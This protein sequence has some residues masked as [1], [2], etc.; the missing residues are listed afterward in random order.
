ME[1]M[2]RRSAWIRIMAVMLALVT[3]ITMM[4]LDTFAAAGKDSG[5]A[6]LQ[7]SEEAAD[8]FVTDAACD[9]AHDDCNCADCA[10]DN[11]DCADQCGE[12]HSCCCEDC[13]G[14]YVTDG[15]TAY[16]DPDKSSC[17]D[18]GKHSYY[19]DPRT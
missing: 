12:S 15:L 16:G 14:H 9:H 2:K 1:K 11:C 3:G 19:L 8:E 7:G 6:Y 17:T 4:P 13:N 5:R 10:L 18:G